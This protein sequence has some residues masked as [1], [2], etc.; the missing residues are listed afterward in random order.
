MPEARKQDATTDESGPRWVSLNEAT[1]LVGA[2]REQVLQ[3]G[4]QGTLK[5]E[6]MGRWTFVTRASIDRY[7]AANGAAAGQ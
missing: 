7:I 3:L 4:I 2:T 6:K 5:V 1:K